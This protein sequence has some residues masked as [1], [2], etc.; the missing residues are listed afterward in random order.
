MT[1]STQAAPRPRSWGLPLLILAGVFALIAFAGTV[2]VAGALFLGVS[3]AE[4]HGHSLPEV[5][6]HAAPVQVEEK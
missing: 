1:T 6:L 4:P 2:L 3:H 5:E